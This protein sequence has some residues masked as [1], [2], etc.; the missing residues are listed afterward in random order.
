MLFRSFSNIQ[1]ATSW[2]VG[3]AG[4][5]VSMHTVTDSP[6]LKFFVALP[7]A[8]AA[9]AA[10]RIRTVA[11]RV[12]MVRSLAI[13]A[14]RAERKP[15]RCLKI[16]MKPV[17]ERILENHCRPPFTR[18]AAHIGAA[19]AGFYEALCLTRSGESDSI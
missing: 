1:L 2:A 11:A 5:G 9:P 4:V 14:R 15:A 12:F 3:T 18:R 6:R 16:V 13:Q 19:R 8:P 17:A 7:A 10:T